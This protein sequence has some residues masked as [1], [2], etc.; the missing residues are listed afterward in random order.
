RTEDDEAP[1]LLCNYVDVYYNDEID[2]SI[3]FMEATANDNELKKFQL[4]EGDVVI[5]KDSEDPNDI[6]VPAFIK[7]TQENLLCGYHLSILRKN[8]VRIDSKYLFWALKDASIISQLHREA[9]G[10]TRWAIS[11]KHVKNSIIPLPPLTE[12]KAIADYLDKACQKIDRIIELKEK[13]V[14]GIEKFYKSRLLEIITGNDQED[15]ELANSDNHV[16]GEVPENW[17]IVRLKHVLS[18]INSGVTP[19]GGATSYVDEGIPLLRSQNIKFEKLHLKNVVHIPL[20]VHHKMSNSKLEYGDVLLNIT[21]ASL[22]RCNYFKEEFQANVNQ[23]VCILRPRFPILTEYLYYVLMSEIGQAQIF[24]GFKGSGR[25]GL[26]F[27]AVKN[28]K[29][30]L[31]DI[32][33]QNIIIKRLNSL[34][35]R[36]QDQKSLIRKQCDNLKS[37]RKSLIH[38]CVTGKKKVYEESSNTGRAVAV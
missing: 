14:E 19:S 36:I 34:S 29:I 27:E 26:N 38:E 8:D 24:S 25:E 35:K 18:K 23:H 13:Q 1:V 12:Q 5:T 6:A 4:K 37:Y 17:K 20:E 28:F 11:T 15:V 33:T 10:I 16:I 21:G 2:N 32:E 7:Q 31:P 30:P 3:N 22:G 9:N